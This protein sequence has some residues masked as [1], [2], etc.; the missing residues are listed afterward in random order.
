MW[1]LCFEKVPTE[2]QFNVSIDAVVHEILLT[3]YQPQQFGN[4][5][6]AGKGQDRGV[7]KFKEEKPTSWTQ[8][9][10][11][12][13]R[14][15]IDALETKFEQL[16]KQVSSIEQRQSSFE[17]KFDGRFDE[18]GDVLR[19]LLNQSSQRSREATGETPPSKLA[20]QGP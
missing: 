10:P 5:K 20:R 13:E 14:A 4:G 2:K 7:K 16:G 19:Q 1:I 15:R 12:P 18:I 8:A 9:A 3:E 17:T 6:A 11:I